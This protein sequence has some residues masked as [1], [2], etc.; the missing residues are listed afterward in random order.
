MLNIPDLSSTPIQVFKLKLECWI[1]F[2]VLVF[3]ALLSAQSYDLKTYDLQSV[4]SQ[5]YVYTLIQDNHDFLWLGTEKGVVRFDGAV[6]KRYTVEDSLAED[7]TTAS[8]LDSKGRIWFGHFE[9]G[10]SV[11]EGNAFKKVVPLGA[12][13]SKISAM[14][15]APDG[16]VWAASQNQGL[17]RIDSNFN[18]EIFD[19]GFANMLRLFSLCF[20]PEGN[21]VLG[22]EEGLK[23]YK[24]EKGKVKLLK[25]VDQI[26][27]TKINAV[28]RRKHRDG[29]YWV[30]T[31]DEGLF[32]Y[33][34]GKNGIEDEIRSLSG[35]SL[36]GI[37]NVT[38]IWE[39]KSRKLWL[40]TFGQGVQP[41]VPSSGE[42]WLEPVRPLL[43]TDSL[44]ED[45]IKSV[46]Q[47]R[48]GQI[49]V[50]TYGNGLIS[51]SEKDLSVFQVDADTNSKGV[52]AVFQDRDKNYWF[53]TDNGLY[54]VS[55]NG[56]GA[57][58]GRYTLSGTLPVSVKQAFTRK[59]GLPSNQISAINQ[60]EEGLLWIGTKEDGVAYWDGS[61]E[62]FIPIQYTNQ[63]L[64]LH[65]K[66][67]E[68]IG[69][70]SVWIASVDG[71]HLYDAKEGS[72][73]Y[74]GT[75]NGIAHNNI[76]DLFVDKEGILNVATHTNRISRF[77]GEDIQELIISDKE[78]IANINCI[79][80]DDDGTM[81]Y[82]TDGKGLYQSTGDTV[83]VIN[84]EDGLLS[85]Y[86][87]Q[88]VVDKFGN[89][90]VTHR[91]GFS[92]YIPRTKTVITYPNNEHF[93]FFSN[94][95]ADAFRDTYGNIWFATSQ[96]LIRYNWVPTRTRVVP[97]MLQI[98]G[99]TVG[100]KA[101][102]VNEP[103]DLPYGDYKVSIDFLGL[104]FMD[105][106]DV[107]YQYKLDGRDDEWSEITPKTNKTFQGLRDGSYTVMV[108]ARNKFGNWN[109]TPASF[110]FSISPPWWK[111]WWFRI[112]VGLLAAL[113][114][115]A[116]V[117]YRV[118]RL[119]KEKAALEE[120]VNERTLELSD[121]KKKLE[122]A[123]LEL[124]KL[125]LVAS[126]TDNA[127][128]I[129]DKD[130]NLEWINPGF[131]RLT[132][133]TFEE[134][135]AI[136]GG[137]SFLDTSTNSEISRL[138]EEVVTNNSSAQYE[139][140]LP[141]KS[142]KPIWVISTLT[143]ILDEEGK[144]RKIVIIDSNITDR[145]QAEEEVQK[146]NERLEQ[147][148]E[149]RTQELAETNLKL[150][151]ENEEHVI[152]GHKL[153]KI[154]RELD[155][156]VYRASHDLKGPLASL[157]GLIGIVQSEVE[158]NESA[159]LYLDLM[160]QRG[161]RLDNILVD[162]IGATQVKQ[163]PIK[164]SRLN[165]L[166][167]TKRVVTEVKDKY[168]GIETQFE[169]DIDPELTAVTDK[170]IFRAVLSNYIENSHKYRNTEK[171]KAHSITRITIEDGNIAISVQDDGTG[172]PENGQDKLF[173]MFFRGTN[174]VSG[175]GLGLY[176]VRQAV[177]KLKG[178]VDATSEFGK[179][180][181]FRAYIPI[182]PD[183]KVGTV[184]NSEY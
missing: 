1:L 153:K 137:K 169:L 147:L 72:G 119:N 36:Y 179:G 73:D 149:E 121:E 38:A 162:L 151:V 143:P 113:I 91:Q 43:P 58:S 6:F 23:I 133:Y 16:S 155:T 168:E 48:F 156:F 9:G 56:L 170:L 96:G 31:E 61:N 62:R 5:G 34:P 70:D 7:L 25:N 83:N 142:G 94:G 76:Y 47:D 27:P 141:S 71:A 29:G 161:Q 69:K 184:I 18:Y 175:S 135:V 109:E 15:P 145:K 45:V 174:K 180:S 32:C 85:N 10:I 49:W 75:R 128:F 107:V 63:K 129:I 125:S 102:S 116:Y 123:N 182:A 30:G 24:Y 54:C 26:P 12:I 11:Y 104:T 106:K 157:L 131:T 21:L 39:E 13:G 99:I 46:F 108:R 95:V 35:E 50:G 178:K 77:V 112:M 150:S 115:F 176:I 64:G 118:Y 3:P 37:E 114:I 53:G 59:D 42:Q 166:D 2:L 173:E 132:G 172:I 167:E 55:P 88:T 22:T 20:S 144:L 98:D 127:V 52:N 51:L 65:V 158:G 14:A 80:Q 100:E 130:G 78:D 90:W 44:G 97:P 165:L 139:S 160:K 124:E 171:E 120:K 66:D 57:G 41:F 110:S 82:G 84:T 154:N 28:V 163:S 105:Q 60:D 40:G 117:K 89:V 8:T 74:F 140:R 136:R 79:G 159:N 152:T 4:K 183:E 148:V 181:T 33:V 134:I 111:T 126:E 92:R 81:W 68:L 101:V 122:V 17:I 19:E 86:C 93:N 164:F 103:L 177:E 146:M 87:Y 67:I 138:V